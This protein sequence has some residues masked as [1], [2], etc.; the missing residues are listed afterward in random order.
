MPRTASRTPKPRKNYATTSPV[1][2]SSG[3][4]R[5]VNARHG[6]NR[7]LGN[8]CLRFAF[9][10]VQASPGAR[11]Y[12]TALRRR[13]K[14]HAQAIRSVATRMVGILHGWLK[15]RCVYDETIAWPPV[16][17]EVG[18]AAWLKPLLRS[19]HVT[20]TTCPGGMARFPRA[21]EATD[22]REIA[23]WLE[24]LA[25]PRA[26]THV[27]PPN[28]FRATPLGPFP[29]GTPRSARTRKEM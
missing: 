24:F 28:L 5:L 12:Y 21:Q 1:T 6:G 14:T 16:E 22:C 25:S 20:L 8:T 27:L 3:K 13:D 19:R 15:K 18:T 29:D 4:V 9:A 11:R 26:G 2:R 10:A 23:P 7:Q 17:A